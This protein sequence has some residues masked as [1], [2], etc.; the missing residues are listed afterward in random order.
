MSDDDD[1]RLIDPNDASR[2]YELT[3]S[4]GGIRPLITVKD[5]TGNEIPETEYDISYSNN[6]G[7]G[8]ATV[9]IT[10]KSD[11]NLYVGSKSQNFKITGYAVNKAVVNYTNTET[12]VSSDISKGLTLIY[13]G[14]A[15]EPLGSSESLTDDIPDNIDVTFTV[16]KGEE[17]IKLKKGRDFTVSYLNNVKV[18]N[19]SLV[20]TGKGRFSGTLKKTVKIKDYVPQTGE[21]LQKHIFV[22]FLNPDI[23]ENLPDIENGGNRFVAEYTYIK[24]GVTPKVRVYYEPNSEVT[25]LTVAPSST[26]IELKEGTDYTLKYTNNKAANSYNAVYGKNASVAPGITITGKKSFKGAVTFTYTILPRNIEEMTISAADKACTGKAGQY[27]VA[28]VINDPFSANKAKLAAGTDYEKTLTYSLAEANYV[29]KYDASLK[30]SFKR[31]I[32]ADTV[33]NPKTDIITDNSAIRVTVTGKGNYTGTVSTVFRMNNLDISK[34]TV[35]VADQNYLGKAVRPGKS[36]ITITMK[37]NG[38]TKTLG[39]ED[40]EIT[41]YQKNTGRGTGV[42]TI[43]G[44]GDYCGYKNVNFKIN[45]RSIFYVVEYKTNS[46]TATGTMAKQNVLVKGTKL[47]ALKYKNP[48][49]EF[50]GWNT[51][52]DGTGKVFFTQIRLNL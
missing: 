3:G 6:T 5:K 25:P 35:K 51:E 40:Y 36:D 21:S 38:V 41:G 50:T 39:P 20:I 14:K 48:G 22:Q 33:L 47:T 9:T 30:R 11:S 16:K 13:N 4:E 46:Q 10:A 7:V 15:Q 8:N 31:W 44:L 19:A 27:T 49:Y 18:G 29:L 23:T 42:V 17:P 34:A 45:A 1:D 28:P 52:A 24:G 37:V 12:G 26:A 43:H 2:S 32:A